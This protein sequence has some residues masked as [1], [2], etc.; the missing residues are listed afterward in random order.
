MPAKV[1]FLRRHGRQNAQRLLILLVAFFSCHSCYRRNP[2]LLA[3]DAGTIKP[4]SS[5]DT[6]DAGGPDA[7]EGDEQEYEKCRPLDDTGP[8]PVELNDIIAVG[9]D[10][11]GTVYVVDSEDTV[12]YRIFISKA[13]TLYQKRITG[14]GTGGNHYLFTVGDEEYEFVLIIEISDDDHME[15][16]LVFDADYEGPI[17]DMPQGSEM[18][19]VLD[20][21]YLSGMEAMSVPRI[22]HIEYFAQLKNGNYLIVVRPEYEWELEDMVLFFGAE[23]NMLHRRI[24]EVSQGGNTSYITFMLDGRTAAVCCDCELMSE[25][26]FDYVEIDGEQIPAVSIDPEETDFDEFTFY[27][28]VS[29]E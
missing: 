6:K 10:S 18:L 8:E 29:G 12:H 25:Y 24:L 9:R 7:S 16:A 13:G 3:E 21:S 27:C 4:D 2:E 26:E 1:S 11:E 17:S 28:M 19:E 20:E 23:K 22:R 5:Q 14:A 15:M